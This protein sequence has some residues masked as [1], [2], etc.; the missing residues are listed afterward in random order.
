MTAEGVETFRI[1]GGKIAEGWS[2]LGP[3]VST[4]GVPDPEPVGEVTPESG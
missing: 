4:D 3:L 2:R 1:A